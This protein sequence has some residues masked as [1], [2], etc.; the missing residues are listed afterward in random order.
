MFA[1]DRR[2]VAVFVLSCIALL[3]T[4]HVS[5]R[6]ER[7]VTQQPANIL[8]Q[9]I[10]ALEE[11]PKHHLAALAAE[12]AAT[13]WQ[14]NLYFECRFLTGGLTTLIGEMKVCMHMAIELGANL[15]VPTTQ[16]RG[17]EGDLS[18]WTDENDRK[19][20]GL[21]F[22][23]EFLIERLQTACPSMHVTKLNDKLEPDIEVAKHITMDYAKSP[24]TW[25]FG[26][27]ETEDTPWQQWF[28][29][30]VH[31][32]PVDGNVVLRAYTP[33]QFFN[34][35]DAR[36]DQHAW[37]EL[38]HLLRSRILPRTAIDLIRQYMAHRNMAPYF[39]VHFRVENDVLGEET[40][41]SPE[42]Q[43][44]R[45]LETVEQ[46]RKQYGYT[47]KNIYLA[48]GDEA[49]IQNFRTKAAEQGW[50]TIGKWS[51]AAEVG[52]ELSSI[53]HALDF[54]HEAMIDMGML[55]LSD[56]FVG[57]GASAFSFTIAHDRSPTGR[58]LGSSLEKASPQAYNARSHLYQD[59]G[60]AYQCCL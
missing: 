43:I 39:G 53:I 46:A 56:F 27:Y 3:L 31:E 12:C 44:K 24:F 18:K 21:W 13:T 9:Q 29:D 38:G 52:D 4:A 41:S 49:Q 55:L 20:L 23:R 28:N 50:T 57:L 42:A 15:I 14:P 60:F 7:H 34:V 22:D 25:G 1:Y 59:G 47:S 17:G 19:P 58:Y 54:D 10:F 33:S 40:W 16:Y 36:H 6:S 26:P 32:G 37:F 8:F 30:T 48:C 45:I 35:T 5:F 11:P 2:I 51:V